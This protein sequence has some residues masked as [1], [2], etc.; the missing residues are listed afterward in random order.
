MKQDTFKKIESVLYLP[1]TQAE[2]A[3]TPFEME[4]RNRWLVCVSKKMEDP[5][6]PDRQLVE[7]LESGMTGK[8]D[9]VAKSTAY[10]DIAAVN[11]ITG[12]IQLAATN[13]YRYMI[14]EGAKK[15]YSIAEAE[16]DSK[17]MSAALDKIG[18]YT[19]ADKPDNDF[20]WDQ[21]LPPVMEPSNDTSLLEGIE[22]ID[23]LEE[24]RKE[25]RRMFKGELRAN[26]TEAIIE[27][28]EQ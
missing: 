15:A 7:M 18:K 20:D 1:D 3:L 8:F 23:N 24:R 2:L 9:P 19:R 27:D 10:R 11:K 6:L 16:R 13:W 14:I 25:M 22:P 5:L 4:R 21:M 26:S 28:E 12:N 17:G